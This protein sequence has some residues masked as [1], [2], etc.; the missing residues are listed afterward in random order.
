MRKRDA[1]AIKTLEV[2]S[3]PEWRKWLSDNYD[4]Q[5]EIWLVFR[6]RHTGHTGHAGHTGVTSLSY[7]DAVE[8]ALCFGWIDSLVRRL[9]DA[10]YA[11]KFTPRKAD[12]KWSTI[13]RRRYADLKSRGLLAAPGLERAPTNRSGDAPRPSASAIP[14]YIEERLKA[15][16]R[17]WHYFEQLAP[18]Y[19]RAYIGWIEAA[20]QE[21]T[22]EKRLREAL[23]LLAAGK[24]LGLK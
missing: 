2:R 15:D 16:P 5:S 13:N 10:R 1:V 9:D 19:R 12:S 20:K 3:R 18:S 14:S 6:K 11:R 7:I 21:E 17:A 4:S 24:K 23:S 8:E 22:K